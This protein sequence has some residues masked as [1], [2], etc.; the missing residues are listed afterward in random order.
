MSKTL[1]VQPPKKKTSIGVILGFGF[2]VLIVFSCVMVFL[3]LNRVSSINASLSEINDK[4]AL[5]QRYAINF[6]GSVHDRAIAVRDVVLISSEDKNGLQ[7]LLEQIN[8]LEKFYKE[9]E[10]NMKQKFIDAKLL[11]KKEL[12]ILHSIEETQAKAIPLIVQI[13]QAKLAGD[14]QK[15]RT[16]LTTL[17]PYFTQWLAEINEFIDYQENANSGLTHQ[18]RSDV[19]E[20][21]I[22]LLVLLACSVIFGV[23]VAIVII[24]N[25]LRL[26]GGEPYIASY[27]VSKIANGDLSGHITYKNKDSILSS[28]ASMQEGLREIVEAITHSS[29]QVNK[30]ALEVSDVARK[31]QD[32]ANTQMQNSAAIVGKIEQINHSVAEVSD[33]AKQTEENSVKSVE[34][35]SKGVEIIN[36]TAQ[37][38][39]KITE[40]I[41]SSADNIRG[42]QQQS[43]EIGGSAGLIAEIADQTNLLALNAAIEAARAGEH[44]R[45]FAVVADEVRKLAE[46]TASTTAEIANMITL[47]QESIGV[48]VNSI[49]AIV[50]QIDKGQKLILDSVHTLEEIQS[51]AQDSLQKAQVVASSSVQQEDTMQSILHDMQSISTLSQE[52]RNSLENTNKAIGELKNISDALKK[53]MT[54]FKV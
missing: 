16:I 52:T 29:Q 11:N 12:S 47:I 33:I 42:L 45:G 5:A 20:F 41:S 18:L 49:E 37:E 40:M 34:I 36:I 35:S 6:R 26:L 44:G 9:A 23:I 48:S 2:G 50:P 14:S 22:L 10:D 31:A 51:Q 13:I 27:I 28:I 21:R 30:I 19:S 43:V 17:S 54:H 7:Q 32:D 25:L 3:S 15:A 1:E 24:R 38:I 4:N 53:N 8:A 39:G 46:R